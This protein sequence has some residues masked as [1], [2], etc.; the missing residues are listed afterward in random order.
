MSEEVGGHPVVPGY[1]K[2]FDKEAA[3]HAKLSAMT[4]KQ[5]ATAIQA[6]EFGSP[7]DSNW[8][9]RA[10]LDAFNIANVTEAASRD[11][12][13]LVIASRAARWAMYAAI[14]TA[15]ALIVASIKEIF[16]MLP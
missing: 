1:G 7:S 6:G 9:M 10:A 4:A 13:A 5:I 8:R 12:R 16:A 2:K 11:D 3:L 14:I 15:A